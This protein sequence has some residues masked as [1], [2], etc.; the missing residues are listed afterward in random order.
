MNLS[1]PVNRR[2]VP[3][4]LLIYSGITVAWVL[5]MVTQDFGPQY[6]FLF[7]ISLVMLLVR[8]ALL[9]VDYIKTL[10]DGRARLVISAE[11]IDDRR[12]IF[13]CGMIPWSDITA[14]ELYR[15]RKMKVL[16]VR[17]INA[18][19]VLA[20]QPFW[21]RVFQREMS[22]RFGSPVLVSQSSVHYDLLL[23]HDELRTFVTYS[24][25]HLLQK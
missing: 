4:A 5:L 22:K 8:V 19:A 3:T 21:K 16:V 6:G 20:A 7:G 9:L 17:L 14:I 12:S 2:R 23:L 25:D 11:G 10:F 24:P 18:E 13:S 1:I 15:R